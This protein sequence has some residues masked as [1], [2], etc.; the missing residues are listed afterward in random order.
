MTKSM[1]AAIEAVRTW[2]GSSQERQLTREEFLALLPPEEAKALRRRDARRQ[3]PPIS[4]QPKLQGW[5]ADARLIGPRVYVTGYC[6]VLVHEKSQRLV[7]YCHI[8]GRWTDPQL[9]IVQNAAVELLPA[10]HFWRG[11]H[12]GSAT[13]VVY[14]GTRQQMVLSDEFR[15]EVDHDEMSHAER[16]LTV[17][18]KLL[19]A[20]LQSATTGLSSLAAIPA[21]P[22]PIQKWL[23]EIRA[24]PLYIPGRG[25][26]WDPPAYKYDKRSD[27]QE[28][29]RDINQ[30]EFLAVGAHQESDRRTPRRG[31]Q[32]SWWNNPIRLQDD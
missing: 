7:A 20:G 1:S 10:R 30:L 22:P 12:I 8:Q 18:R 28:W 16:V 31:F 4:E 19:A 25:I 2:L 14:L 32:P 27:D 11:S 15:D 17:A 26:G 24:D 6:G 23:A 13:F 21:P 3:G 9:A 5:H 29:C